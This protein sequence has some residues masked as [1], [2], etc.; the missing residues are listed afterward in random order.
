MPCNSCGLQGVLFNPAQQITIQQITSHNISMQ[1]GPIKH[2]HFS[3]K[4]QF[5]QF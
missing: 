1:T 4:Q 3:T 2:E 5:T